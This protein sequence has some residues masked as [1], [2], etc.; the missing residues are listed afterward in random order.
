MALSAITKE[1]TTQPGILHFEEEQ[2][3]E[4]ST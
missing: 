2:P 3:A 1:E 4:L